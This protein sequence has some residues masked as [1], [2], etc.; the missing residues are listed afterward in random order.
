MFN[1]KIMKHMVYYCSTGPLL[2]LDDL[3]SAQKQYA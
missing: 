1:I 2:H 3:Y